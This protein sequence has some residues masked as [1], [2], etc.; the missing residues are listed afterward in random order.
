MCAKDAVVCSVSHK[1]YSSA[2][3]IILFLVKDVPRENLMRDREKSRLA[4]NPKKHN[5]LAG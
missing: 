1:R 2:H 4:G 5:I 3:P